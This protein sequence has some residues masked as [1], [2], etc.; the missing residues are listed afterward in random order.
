MKKFNVR[1]SVKTLGR[2][3]GYLRGYRFHLISSLLLAALSVAL[4]LYV[5]ILVGNAIDC[6]VGE[7]NVDFEAILSILGKIAVAVV[8]TALAQWLMNVLGNHMTYGIVA[9]IRR[10]AFC[11][12]Q[13]LPLSYLDSHPSGEIVSRVI[14]DTDQFADGVLLG[15][16]QLFTGVITILGTLGF[17]LYLNWRVALVVLLVT[18][19]SIAVASFISSPP[20]LRSATVLAMR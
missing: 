4:T 1:S 8:I 14:S 20:P 11:H 7:G 9:R 12:I 6:A 18:P 10:D 19:L 3:F 13:R 2:V 5:P 15:F 17:M 16:S